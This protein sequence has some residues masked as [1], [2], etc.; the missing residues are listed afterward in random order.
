MSGGFPPFYAGLQGTEKTALWWGFPPGFCSELYKVYG[1][2][3]VK[4]TKVRL[5][6]AAWYD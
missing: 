3:N 4:A 2:D 5:H 1:G 6:R